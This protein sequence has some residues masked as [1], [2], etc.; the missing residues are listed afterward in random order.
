[1][2]A[3]Y[4]MRCLVRLA[5]LMSTPASAYVMGAGVDVEG[6]LATVYSF[7]D[8]AILR[9]GLAPVPSE[10]A[11]T[12]KEGHCSTFKTAGWG[13]AGVFRKSGKKG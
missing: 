11:A 1:L 3:K 4:L 2:W 7:V 13:M 5:R 8:L 12:P 9:V 10:A 6:G